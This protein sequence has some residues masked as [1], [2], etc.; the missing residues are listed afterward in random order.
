MLKILKQEQFFFFFK[1]LTF[2]TTTYLRART[3]LVDF[4]ARRLWLWTPFD[5]KILLVFS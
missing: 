5:K 2:S 1:R 3:N 4:E